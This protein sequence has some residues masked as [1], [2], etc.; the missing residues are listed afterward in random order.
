MT[1][2]SNVPTSEYQVNDLFPAN[3]YRF[4][5]RAY[6]SIKRNASGFVIKNG[7][8]ENGWA[9]YEGSAVSQYITTDCALPDQFD[10]PVLVKAEIYSLSWYVFFLL[11]CLFVFVFLGL[12]VLFVCGRCP[13]IVTR[14]FLILT[15]SFLFLVGELVF[16]F[17]F[18]FSIC[19]FYAGSFILLF[20]FFF[21]SSTFLTTTANGI[22]LFLMVNR[23]V[24]V[25]PCRIIIFKECSGL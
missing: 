22:Y 13:N 21:S 10:P 8:Q 7:D 12:G 20:L 15:T 23:V 4:R 2:S 17:P 11:V 3:S 25:I 19:S 5:I 9:S 18:H 6:Y 1:I 24:M 14:V 16:S